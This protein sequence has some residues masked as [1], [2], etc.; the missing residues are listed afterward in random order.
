MPDSP[1]PQ[2]F[3][4]D[5]QPVGRRVQVGKGA[6]LLEICPGSRVEL[7]ACWGMPP[8]EPAGCAW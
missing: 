2:T 7:V 6:T 3:L 1:N 4:V 8:V 5:L